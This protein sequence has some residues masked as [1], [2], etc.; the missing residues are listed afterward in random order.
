MIL[1]RFNSLVVALW[2]LACGFVAQAHDGSSYGGLF[3]SRDAGAAWLPAD[4]GLFVNLSNA[5]AVSPTD[6]NHLLYGADGRLLRSRNGGRDWNHEAPNLIVGPIFSAAFSIDGKSAYATNGMMLF[7]HDGAND[8]RALDVPVNALPIKQI[9]VAGSTLYLAANDGVYVS[10]DQGKTWR[11]FAAGLPAEPVSVLLV[12]QGEP[13]ST[14]NA[15]VGGRLWWS[16]GGA[17]QQAKGD[18]SNQ[19][20][21]VMIADA[22]D[23]KRLWAAGS[24]RIFR[25]DDG[26]RSW[27]RHGNPLND[28]NLFLRGLAVAEDGNVIAVTTHRG[29]VRSGDGGK[30]WDQVEGAL[31]LHLECGPLLQD[32]RDGNTFYVGFALR[33]YSEPWN[34]AQ[35]LAEQMRSDAAR[36]R[37]IGLGG[38]GT[39]AVIFVAIWLVSRK[40]TAL[41]VNAIT[42]NKEQS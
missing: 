33:P 40:R 15:V 3:R 21:D 17:W 9:I 27:Q 8:W 6:G 36:K 34:V 35:Q 2:L 7:G 11:D 18:W 28:P 26:G 37:W 22:S 12:A 38:V 4:P 23:A 32:L 20:V 25:S 29:L 16:D 30:T 10:G 19:R 13:G 39:L 41:A 42:R 5:I 14:M 24:S 31:P 1:I